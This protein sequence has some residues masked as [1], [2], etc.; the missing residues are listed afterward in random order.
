MTQPCSREGE[1]CLI[2]AQRGQMSRT[3]HM[4]STDKTAMDRANCWLNVDESPSFLL[5]LL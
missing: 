5:G 2:T 4:V 1:R 3:P